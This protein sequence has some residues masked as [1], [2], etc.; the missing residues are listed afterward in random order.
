MKK[1]FKIILCIDKLTYD[2]I[3]KILISEKYELLSEQRFRIGWGNFTSTVL[4]IKKDDNTF[5]L[6]KF[7]HL[8]RFPIFGRKKSKIY[9]DKILKEIF[10]NF[11]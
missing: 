11:R 6:A 10:K 2:N 7:P 9:L 8:S 1:K 3:K 4:K 5:T